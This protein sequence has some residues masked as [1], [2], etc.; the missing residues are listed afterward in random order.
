[1]SNLVLDVIQKAEHGDNDAVF[2]LIK[3]CMWNGPEEDLDTEFV[4]YAIAYYQKQAMAGNTDAMIELG[5]VYLEGRGVPKDRDL[6]KFW[7]QKAVDAGNIK[8]YRLLGNYYY[9]DRDRAGRPIKNE[10]EKRLEMGCEVFKK[11]AEL[12]EPSCLHELGDMYMNGVT[13]EQDY[14]QAFECYKQGLKEINEHYPKHPVY[15]FLNYRLGQC[16]HHGY[17]VEK[18]LDEAK[19]YLEKASQAGERRTL[20]GKLAD[21]ERAEKAFAELLEVLEEMRG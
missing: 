16:Y 1:M 9:Y 11:G 4:Y 13:V 7:Y 21:R 8:A 2:N 15:P 14:D 10:N 3:Y 20:S 5:T 18:D 19:K 6:A 17:G 12:G